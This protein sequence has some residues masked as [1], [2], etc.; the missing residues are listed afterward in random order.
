[1]PLISLPLI[2]SPLSSSLVYR[3]RRAGCEA[4][5]REDAR[6]GSQ[7]RA[8]ARP[9]GRACEAA[10]RPSG[11]GVRGGGAAQREACSPAAVPEG[12]CS[13][14]AAAVW[15]GARVGARARICSDLGARKNMDG[16]VELCGT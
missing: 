13:P 12:A 16:S 8:A 5:T 10:A 11:R 1:T 4:A 3:A 2:S 7:A 14:A 9:R 15:E 6:G